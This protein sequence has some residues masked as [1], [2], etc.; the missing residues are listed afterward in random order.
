[1][2]APKPT[3]GYP[4]RTAAVLALRQE[5]KD[6]GEIS[7]VLDIPPG[8]IAALEASA[9]R[10]RARRPAETNGRTV[11][12][13]TDILDRLRPHAERR[14]ISCNELARRIV[15]TAIEDGMVDAILDDAET[16]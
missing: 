7:A 5:G 9:T 16:A 10:M 1:M 6:T 14:G 2:G 4:S 15:D 11:V 12:F 13:P 8:T 3:M